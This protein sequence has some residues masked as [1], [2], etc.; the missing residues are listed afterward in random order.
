MSKIVH[1]GNVALE[2]YVLKGNN[3]FRRVYIFSIRMRQ[4]E[5]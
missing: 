3:R 5:D 4:L 2:E 1:K